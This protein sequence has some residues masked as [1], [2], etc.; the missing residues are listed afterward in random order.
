MVYRGHVC[1]GV[2]V[3]DPPTALPDGTPV[4][5]EPLPAAADPG[6]FAGVSDQAGY[7]PAALEAM[8]T[9]LTAEQFEAL[10]TISRQGGPDVDAIARLRAA[11]LT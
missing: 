7:D 9:M 4:R 10:E 2:V 6:C 8:R 1:N 3:F 11:S 5:V